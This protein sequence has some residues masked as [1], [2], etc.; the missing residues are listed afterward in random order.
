MLVDYDVFMKVPKLDAQDAATVQRLYD[1]KDLD[2]RLR[3]GSAA[4]DRGVALPTVTDGFTGTGA[5]SR[6]AR[7]RSSCARAW[8]ASA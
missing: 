5:R 8:A 3:A 2:F 4:V 1:A 7:A 6:R